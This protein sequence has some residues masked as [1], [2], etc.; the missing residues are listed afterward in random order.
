MVVVW[1][2][3]FTCLYGAF[4]FH[5]NLEKARKTGLPYTFS[6]INE[7]QIW[8]YITDP[9][10]RWKCARYLME[11]QGW[12]R[13]ARFMV[14]D[15]MYEDKGRAHDEFGE[16]FLVVSPGGIVC[17]V[18]NS[19]TANNVCTRRKDFVKPPEKMSNWSHHFGYFQAIL[20]ILHRDAR[21]LW[22]KR[23]FD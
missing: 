10:L 13:W 23:C 15:W 1:F 7:F 16:V 17:Y 18:A 22:S 19:K 3:L 12:P 8:A 20:L 21:A 11:E 6:L 2:L 14:K 5:I 9:L 4:Y